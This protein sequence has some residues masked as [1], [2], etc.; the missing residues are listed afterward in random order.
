MNAKA[1]GVKMDFA[2]HI[3]YESLYSV[4]L[5]SCL[6]I[7]IFTGVIFYDWER[8]ELTTFC[9]CMDVV[10]YDLTMSQTNFPRNTQWMCS[11]DRRGLTKD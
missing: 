6:L 10:T 9:I 11:S 2:V 1:E 8:L 5:R 7:L 4:D 3:C